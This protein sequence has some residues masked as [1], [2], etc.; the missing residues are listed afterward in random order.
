MKLKYEETQDY[1]LIEKSIITKFRPQIWRKFIKGIV[2]YELVSKGDKIAVCISGGKDSLLLAKLF[3][4]YKKHINPDIE[5]VYICMDPG[6]S[7]E[8]REMLE[9]TVKKLNIPLKI[10]DSKIFEVVNEIAQDYPCYM[11]AKMRRGTL[12]SYAHELGCNKIALG[13]HYDDFVETILLNVFYSGNYKTMIPK[14]KAKNYDNIELIRP[15]ILLEEKD[16]I[17]YN[18]YN[19]INNM[20]CGCVI[21][22]KEI[23]S[24]RLEMKHLIEELAKNNK[25]VKRSIFASAQNVNVDAILGWTI[26]GEKKTFLDE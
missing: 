14:L 18:D 26:N 19:K 3:E 24:K 21:A 11:C 20:D 17:E 8:N 2:K 23:S 15:L 4:E 6:F 22:A 25:G 16:I 1:K 5:L 10:Y 12:Y 9:D 7:K 13:H